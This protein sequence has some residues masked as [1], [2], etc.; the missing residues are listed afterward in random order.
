MRRKIFIA[1]LTMFVASSAF[2]IDIDISKFKGAS[3]PK[4][5][6]YEQKTHDARIFYAQNN[7]D[8]TQNI[9][10]SIPVEERNSEH[11]LLLGNIMQD[12]DDTRT[13]VSMYEQAI[14]VNRKC[15]RAYYNLGC[16][17]FAEEKYAL[18]LE[19]FKKAKLYKLDLPVIYY[20]LGCTYL[21]LGNYRKAKNELLYAI[22][23]KKD[24]PDY[25]YN[26]AYAYKK[27]NNEKKAKT[28]LDLYE[29]LKLQQDN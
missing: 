15:Y 18:A 22:E 12:K 3:E 4:T 1:L 17:Y 21:V 10:L 7:L 26:V 8:E 2:A 29:Q 11:W 28:Y 24:E 5:S 16:L 6:K 23:L 20:N 25:Y 27:L 19:N 13:A 9:L 14:A